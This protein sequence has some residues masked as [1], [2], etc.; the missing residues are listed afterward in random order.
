[1]TNYMAMFSSLICSP[2]HLLIHRMLPNW[3]FLLPFVVSVQ[4]SHSVK[5]NSLQ[6]HGPQHTRL[7]C[8]SSSC[9]NSCPL[10]RWCHPNITSSVVPF[11][12]LQSFPAS[13]SFQWVDSSQQVAEVLELQL[14][15]QSFQWIFRTD[16]LWDRLVWSPWCNSQES[17]AT[18]QIK[19][20]NSLALSLLYGP[21][22][23]T[24]HDYWKNHSSD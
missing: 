12:C 19:S 4:L 20:I 1:M 14:Q 23:T 5:S 6:S 8:P 21:T 17:S 7:P 13:G 2:A 22:L 16:F 18:P 11:S 3:T 10:S 9:S 24:V 15:Y